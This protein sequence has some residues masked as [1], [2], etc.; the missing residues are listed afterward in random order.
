MFVVVNTPAH[1][2]RASR[3][4]DTLMVTFQPRFVFDDISED[5]KQGRN[6]RTIIRGRLKDY[7][8]V[9]REPAAGQLRRATAT[10][11]GRSTSSRTTIR[12]AVTGC[13]MHVKRE[14]QVQ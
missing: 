14:E 3:H 9:P 4:F 1:Q 6:A 10:A 8:H 7:D 12:P 5:S 2:R 11:S 13:P